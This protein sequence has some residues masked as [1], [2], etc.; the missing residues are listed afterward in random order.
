M[1]VCSRP[2]AALDPTV[3]IRLFPKLKL[4]SCAR[5]ER[6]P[7]FFVSAPESACSFPC[8]LQEEQAELHL[9]CTPMV[10]H[11]NWGPVT[12]Q[13]LA[14]SAP[15]AWLRSRRGEILLL[16]NCIFSQAMRRSHAFA[17]GCTHRLAPENDA[18]PRCSSPRARGEGDEARRETRIRHGEGASPRAQ[19]RVNAPPPAALRASTFPRARGALR[20]REGRGESGPR[21]IFARTNSN[22]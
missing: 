2:V 11:E 14:A 15:A 8:C 3:Q 21:A 10:R 1:G 4:A 16:S 22:S 18:A 5:T 9:D 12:S 17:W 13:Q 7:G 6:R 19:T 20:P